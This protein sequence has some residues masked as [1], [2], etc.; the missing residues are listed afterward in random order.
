MEKSFSNDLRSILSVWNILFSKVS[1]DPVS[2]FFPQAALIQYK[3]QQAAGIRVFRIEGIWFHSSPYMVPKKRRC[4]NIKALNWNPAIHHQDR[5][6]PIAL[7][8]FMP[9]ADV[10]VYPH[11]PDRLQHF[12]TD[13]AIAGTISVRWTEIVFF[14]KFRQLKEASMNIDPGCS[15]TIQE[16][17]KIRPGERF[18]SSLPFQGWTWKLGSLLNFP[19]T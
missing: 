8:P 10:S 17:I 13:D 7:M 15:F 5:T 6:L 3:K 2:T 4:V 14:E 16:G 18:R 12:L 9:S 11:I 19:P 1:L